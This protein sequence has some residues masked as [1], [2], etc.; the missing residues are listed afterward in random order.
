[1][2]HKAAAMLLKAVYRA[3][4]V[5]RLSGQTFDARMLEYR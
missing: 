2:K 5:L 4:A 1:M 3:S